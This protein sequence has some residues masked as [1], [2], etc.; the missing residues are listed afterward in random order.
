VDE[1]L[2]LGKPTVQEARAIKRILDVF[3][4]ASGMQLNLDKSNIFFFNTPII[5]Q[6]RIARILGFQRSSL[7]S[8]YLRAPLL[9]K[10][11]HNPGWQEILT[12][13]EDCLN[14]WT[15]RFLTLPWLNSPNKIC[16]NGHAYL[17]VFC[18]CISCKY[19]TETQIY[20]E[21]FLVGRGTKREKKWAL[22]SWEKLCEPKYQGGLG[23]KDP[24]KMGQA[25]ADKIFWRWIKIPEALWEKIWQ[26]K[27]ARDI[28]PQ[29]WIRLDG[30]IE[31]AH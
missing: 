28:P 25:L 30:A 4:A 21:E 1:T 8:K 12:K 22:I 20:S 7:P 10:A 2:L 26:D 13:I 17:C 31:Q 6:Q 14:C 18:S 27:Y 24:L 15:H 5:I 16:F 9:D 3:L 19:Y 23:L 11:I 29:D